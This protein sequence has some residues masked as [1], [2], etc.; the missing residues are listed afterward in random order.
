[1]AVGTATQHPLAFVLSLGLLGGGALIITVSL[2]TRGPLVFLPY[3]LIVITGA[4]YLR[5]ERVQ[6]FG[7]R[8]ALSLGSFM[9]ATVLLYLFI[10]LVHAK[11]LLKISL[12]GHA[13]RLG[14]M[15]LIGAALSAAVAQLTSTSQGNG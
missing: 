12:F 9:F 1:M 11:S 2:T 10:G 13:W 5:V 6:G 7:N 15:L 3:A 4:V 14:L 8:F